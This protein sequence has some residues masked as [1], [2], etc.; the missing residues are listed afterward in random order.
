MSEQ[1]SQ[2]TRGGFAPK[3]QA[4]KTE[5]NDPDHSQKLND[6]DSYHGMGDQ[7]IADQIGDEP[8]QTVPKPE[9]DET[10]GE[11]FVK[12]PRAKRDAI[13]K[14]HTETRASQ[15]TDNPDGLSEEA[16]QEQA[17]RMEAEARGEEWTAET[18]DAVTDQSN[19]EFDIAAE[20]T[21]QQQ[22]IDGEYEEVSTETEEDTAQITGDVEESLDDTPPEQIKIKVYGEEQYATVEEVEAAGGIEILQ[23]TRAA[24]E[25]LRR[26]A[27]D[28]RNLEQRTSGLDQRE[29][30]LAEREARLAD[31]ENA[32]KD[33][34]P[35]GHEDGADES[36]VQAAA[37]IYSGDPQKAGAA[38]QSI[39]QQA[40]EADRRQRG[41]EEPSGD[42]T[43]Q[44]PST[45]TTTSTAQ[46]GGWTEPER[47]AINAVF[48]EAE[49]GSVMGRA[50]LR[51]KV[52]QEIEFRQELPENAGRPV[53]DIAREAGKY[54]RSRYV[55]LESANILET[56]EFK[57][58]VAKKRRSPARTTVT[59]RA[60]AA[61]PEV[62]KTE[63]QRRKDAV[64]QIQEGRHQH[65]R[66][67]GQRT[68]AS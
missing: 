66:Q 6:P 31:R 24:D 61:E 16:L 41:H 17:R 1:G 18:P 13:A 55:A 36:Y 58:R 50:D 34:P 9:D 47:L 32:P 39:V 14:K 44:V 15:T 8:V 62:Q 37:E 52:V 19:T 49:F 63:G 53:D 30:E 67:S 43:S 35:G 11:S 68:Q 28:R 56:D 25:G 57:E 5:R 22:E 23:K 4:K 65:R 40:I 21:R 33:P 64:R 42:E 46:Q 48:H 10:V 2:E 12:D 27:T 38:L 7:Q 3:S 59:T 51:A 60:P 20:I 26:L 45:E 54:I 29:A